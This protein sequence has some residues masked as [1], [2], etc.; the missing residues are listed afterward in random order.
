MNIRF[1]L[2]YIFFLELGEKTREFF[3]KSG[4]S[5]ERLV[6]IWCAMKLV[7]VQ[8]VDLNC[9]F[10]E[11]GGYSESLALAESRRDRFCDRHVLYSGCNE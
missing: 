1:L 3:A 9:L 10:Q 5:K 2:L 6:N 8:I 11:F 4:L 7:L